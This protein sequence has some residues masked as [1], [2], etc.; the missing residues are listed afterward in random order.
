MDN[1]AQI[2]S[3]SQE[4]SWI[5]PD[6]LPDGGR[7]YGGG[8][9]F[10]KFVKTFRFV[11]HQVF[12]EPALQKAKA[13]VDAAGNFKRRERMFVRR[14]ACWRRVGVSSLEQVCVC[15]AQNGRNVSLV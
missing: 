10:R 7:T 4:L 11:R 6:G 15:L 2:R 14:H 8:V 13:S 9:G 5:C 12:Q 1:T 3:H